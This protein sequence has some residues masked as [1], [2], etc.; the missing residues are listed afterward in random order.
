MVALGTGA[1]GSVEQ[2]VSSAGTNIVY[3]KS[4]NYTRGGD[5]VGILLV[6]ALQIL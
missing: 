2:E 6:L 3:V 1:R 4:G 5:G